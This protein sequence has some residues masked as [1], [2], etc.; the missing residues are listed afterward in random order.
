M[1][2]WVLK[3]AL[4]IGG[5][6]LLM[7]SS[8]IGCSQFLA[9]DKADLISSQASTAP[10][11]TQVKGTTIQIPTMFNLLAVNQAKVGVPA[12]DK[13]K[14]I[15]FKHASSLER[16]NLLPESSDP[17][18]LNSSQQMVYMLAA[19]EHCL[20]LVKS[21]A[22][23]LDISKASRKIFKTQD[24]DSGAP[25]LNVLEFQIAGADLAVKFWRRSVTN[26][27]KAMILDLYSELTT[28]SLTNQQVLS[29]LCTGELASA[30]SLVY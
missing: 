9:Q 27:E 30:S 22:T 17:G 3:R 29:S 11:V 23:V 28:Q 12:S 2:M 15:Y 19:E 10:A 4:K 14:S 5:L 21:E 20:D 26:E 18:K 16:G 7:E 24:L 8:V 13:T 25:P 1:N 6:F